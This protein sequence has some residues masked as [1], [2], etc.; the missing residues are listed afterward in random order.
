MDAFL[1]KD[2]KSIAVWGDSFR[3][4]Y[5]LDWEVLN[6]VGVDGVGGIFPFFLFFFVFLRFFVVF[7]FS[8]F[9]FVF[10]RFSS[11]FAY[12]P[13]TRANDCNLLG[14]WGISLRPRLHR[15]RSELPEILRDH[16]PPKWRQQQ[17]RALV[18]PVPRL[19]RMLERNNK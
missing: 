11:F 4:A 5:F 13:G 2:V 16:R 17:L 7:R 1:G 8:S 18:K 14:K 6:G 10:L 19:E 15:P 12:S 3:T 9:F